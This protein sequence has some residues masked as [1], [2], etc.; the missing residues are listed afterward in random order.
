M[1]R[2]IPPAGSGNSHALVTLMP[3]FDYLCPQPTSWNDIHRQLIVFRAQQ[4]P[5]SPPPPV[6][7]ILAGWAH[8]SDSDKAERWIQTAKWAEDHGAAHLI[9]VLSEN[10][11]YRA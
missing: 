2:S 11:K 5:E 4:C 9:P 8:S 1:A 6:P 7:L 3:A 10:D